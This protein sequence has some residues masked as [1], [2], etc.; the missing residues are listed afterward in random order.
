[1]EKCA[2]LLDDCPIALFRNTRFL[3]GVMDTQL[4]TSAPGLQVR[5][6]CA[7]KIFSPSIQVQCFDFDSQIALYPGLVSFVCIRLL[8]FCPEKVNVGKA[9]LVINVSV[10]IS[11]AAFRLNWRL[12]S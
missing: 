4:L 3:M 1:M 2:H 11:L 8:V 5:N 12:P 6:K 10:N 7:T 9:A